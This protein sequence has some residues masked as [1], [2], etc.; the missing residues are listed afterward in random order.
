MC[1]LNKKVLITIFILKQ[2]TSCTIDK[3]RNST[4]PKIKI[5]KKK[6]FYKEQNYTLEFSDYFFFSAKSIPLYT[7]YSNSSGCQKTKN[8][9]LSV[10]RQL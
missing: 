9:K 5:K 6:Q 2:S 8:K 10:V 1:N 7:D 3:G 4:Q